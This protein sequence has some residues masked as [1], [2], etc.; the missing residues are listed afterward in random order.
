[1]REIQ[2]RAEELAKKY[3]ATLKELSKAEIIA[4][5]ELELKDFFKALDVAK[6]DEEIIEAVRD[7]FARIK[8]ILDNK[9]CAEQIVAN[10]V[11]HTTELGRV[12]Q[13]REGNP[14]DAELQ[15]QEAHHESK[16]IHNMAVAVASELMDKGRHE[17][18]YLALQGM[19]ESKLK[20]L[21]TQLVSSFSKSSI[22]LTPLRAN[23]HEARGVTLAAE[24]KPKGKALNSFEILGNAGNLVTSVTDVASIPPGNIIADLRDK[25]PPIVTSTEPSKSDEKETLASVTITAEVAEAVLAN[26]GPPE[27]NNPLPKQDGKLDESANKEKGDTAAKGSFVVKKEDD[28]RGHKRFVKRVQSRKPSEED[29]S[30]G[31]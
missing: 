10:I 22:F 15:R 7:N 1:M 27:T 14:D 26:Q 25:Q 18:V 12:K 16:L 24:P 30:R 13:A 5:I 4:K 2:V 20:V 31:L 28:G 8:E 21:D 19:G 6:T 29:P 9:Q 3:K 11:E 17:N 23:I